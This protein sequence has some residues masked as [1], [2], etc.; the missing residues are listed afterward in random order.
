MRQIAGQSGVAVQPHNQVRA[1]AAPAA[2]C[3]APSAWTVRP[4]GL[5]DVGLGQGAQKFFAEVR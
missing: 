5:E 4:F 1:A 3:D 2:V